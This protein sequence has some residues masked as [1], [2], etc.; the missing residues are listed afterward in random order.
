M[1]QKTKY[2]WDPDKK[3][4][5]GVEFPINYSFGKYMDWKGYQDDDGLLAAEM[6]Y[7]INT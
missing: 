7:G 1:F 6:E 2:V 3:N 4:F 5:R